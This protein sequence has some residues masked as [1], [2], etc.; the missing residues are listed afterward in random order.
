M[1]LLRDSILLVHYSAKPRQD[2]MAVLEER[3]LVRTLTLGDYENGVSGNPK[4][5]VLDVPL[6]NEVQV[7]RL[8]EALNKFSPRAVRR[9]FVIDDKRRILMA[10]AT[11]CGAEA[12]LSRPLRRDV[13]HSTIDQILHEQSMAGSHDTGR[14][15]LDAGVSAL[16]NIL[17]F[18][19]SSFELTQDEL[20]THGD[21]IIDAIADIG[22][23]D[24]VEIVARHH[25]QTFRHSLLVT[26][27]AVGFGHLLGVGH[28]DLRR[29]ALGSLLHDVGK[30]EIPVSILEKPS[31][32]TP[33]EMEA[34]RHHPEF[35]RDILRRKGGFSDEMIDIVVHHHEMLDGTGYPDALAGNQIADIVRAVTICDIFAALIEE[36]PYKRRLDAGEAYDIMRGMTGKL[37][38]ALMKEFAHVITCT[39]LAISA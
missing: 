39:P 37:D 30:A 33:D 12:V 32:L 10:R 14:F 6:D 4:L 5:V 15:A 2:L 1:R 28:R 25:S 9:V 27:V 34:M 7:L 16:D 36:R 20:Y 21:Q 17:R 23:G 19:T 18:A 8:R 35:G 29:L 22:L 38:P 13:V 26:G 11:V 31:A 3:Y 24:W